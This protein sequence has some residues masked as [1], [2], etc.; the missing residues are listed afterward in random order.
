M[1]LK[2]FLAWVQLKEKLHNQNRDKTIIKERDI[3]W[4]SIGCNVGDKVDGKSQ[5]FNRPVLII[6]KFNKNIFYGMPLTT[7]LKDNPYYVA[8]TFQGRTISA[9]LSH[10]RLLDKRRLQGKM[11]QLDQKD[12]NTV[13]EE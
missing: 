13:K 4:C 7:K 12:F 9:M 1:F 3:W 10:M 8:F 6:K 5:W 11:G 2:N